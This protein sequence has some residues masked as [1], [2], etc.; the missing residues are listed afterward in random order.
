MK[1]KEVKNLKGTN[2]SL[3]LEVSCRR[4]NMFGHHL[5]RCPVTFNA[6]GTRMHVVQSTKRNTNEGSDSPSEG[7]Q[8]ASQTSASD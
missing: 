6:R 7:N 1:L 8:I 4:C 2:G 3:F 5:S